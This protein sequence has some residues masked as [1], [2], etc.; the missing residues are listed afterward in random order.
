MKISHLFSVFLLSILFCGSASAYGECSH[1][2]GMVQYD[3]LRGTCKCM[4]G[5][6]F[7]DDILGTSCISKHSYCTKKYG[8][9]A[10]Y[11]I[12][13]D[14]C[15]CTMGYIMG[16]DILG[17]RGC[18]SGESKCREQLGSFASYNSLTDKCQCDRGYIIQYGRC[19]SLDQKCKD[20]LGL[21]ST[22]NVLSDTCQCSIGY[23]IHNGKC[24]YSDDICDDKLGS[25]SSL[26]SITDKC[27][28]DSGYVLSLKSYGSGYECRSCADKH[29]IN[30]EYDYISK[31]CECKNGYTPDD[32]DQCVKKQNNVYFTLHELDEENNRAIIESD[33]NGRYYVVEYGYGCYDHSFR[34]YLNDRIVVN[35]G[36]DFDLDTYDRIVLY[37][38]DEVCDIRDID[39]VGSYYSFE[40]EEE[41]EESYVPFVPLA[42][43]KAP[44]PIQFLPQEVT[45]PMPEPPAPK[46]I[47]S[48]PECF[49]NSKLNT[50]TQKCDC[51][52]GYGL[53]TNKKSCIK[54]PENAHYVDSP[55]DVWLCDDGYKEEGNNCVSEVPSDSE[56]SDTELTENNPPESKKRRSLWQWI[57]SIISF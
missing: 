11:D 49:A 22:Y 29:G 25:H 37:D 1:I 3:S 34:R 15:E 40:D 5:Y 28:C 51:N 32:D 23:Y 45:A 26:N 17:N 55:T 31:E 44:K 16:T 8:F 57:K 13:N 41:D 56:S 14:S 42:N 21:H 35:L 50:E 27:E 38:D 36:T 30:A 7:Y 2:G 48:K 20:Q 47:E 4:Y 46:P 43:P 18:V 24:V 33:Y 6:I 54:I 10:S 53:T 19:V 12:L 9:M 52:E 39:R